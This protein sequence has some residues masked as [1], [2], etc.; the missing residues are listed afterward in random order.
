MARL[1]NIGH[2]QLHT[3]PKWLIRATAIKP[4]N[5]AA[6]RSAVTRTAILGGAHLKSES[7]FY[8]QAFFASSLG[9]PLGKGVHCERSPCLQCRVPRP[10]HVSCILP[11]GC[12]M[13]DV[14]L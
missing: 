4:G 6:S 13:P 10:C 5:S 2:T 12:N 1:V 8:L 3:V 11:R 7:Q 14:C 9:W